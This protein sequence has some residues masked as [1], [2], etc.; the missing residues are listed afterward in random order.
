LRPGRRKYEC[1]DL[2]RLGFSPGIVHG[3]GL[4]PAEGEEIC[5]V[6]HRFVTRRGDFVGFKFDPQAG[7]EQAGGGPA[8]VLNPKIYNERSAGVGMPSESGQGIP[9]RSGRP[10]GDGATASSCWDHLKRVDWKAR[11]AER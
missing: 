10:A 8:L 3:N 1:S 9:I 5:V 7:R 6:K 11:R 2:V 4:G